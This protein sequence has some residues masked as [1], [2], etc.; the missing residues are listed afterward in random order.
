MFQTVPGSEQNWSKSSLYPNP[1]HGETRPSEKQTLLGN[2]RRLLSAQIPDSRG[3][4]LVPSVHPPPIEVPRRSMGSTVWFLPTGTAESQWTG[5]TTC[6]RAENSVPL[7]GKRKQENR[8]TAAL[9]QEP[10]GQSSHC[11]K[12][13]AS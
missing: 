3:K 10:T 11:Q 7:T 8:S 2:K 4:H 13:Q 6:L 9:T 5:A 1:E 12:E